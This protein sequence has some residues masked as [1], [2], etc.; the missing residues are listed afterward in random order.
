MNSAVKPVAFE[1]KLTTTGCFVGIM[2][3]IGLFVSILFKK[4]TYL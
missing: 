2:P 4:K 3:D 1:K